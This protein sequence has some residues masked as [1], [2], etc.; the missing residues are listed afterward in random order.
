MDLNSG[1]NEIG[2]LHARHG[3]SKLPYFIDK[4][5]EKVIVLSLTVNF[6]ADETLRKKR[7][8]YL[9]FDE[10]D[11]IKGVKKIKKN[12]VGM[13]EFTRTIQENLISLVILTMSHQLTSSD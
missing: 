3:F 5:D 11:E 6:D 4:I 9:A 12:P 7:A 1:I 13:D 2:F 8:F 10:S